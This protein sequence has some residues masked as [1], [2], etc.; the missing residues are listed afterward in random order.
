M[1]LLLVEQK[2]GAVRVVCVQVDAGVEIEFILV[3]PGENGAIKSCHENGFSLGT[4]EH[5]DTFVWFF[6]EVVDD[7]DNRVGKRALK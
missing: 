3:S 6:L 1:G 2:G 7:I 4:N 5:G